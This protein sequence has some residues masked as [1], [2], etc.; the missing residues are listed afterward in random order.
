VDEWIEV[1]VVPVD[2]RNP[3]PLLLDVV[4][5]L[6]HEQLG[7]EVDRWFY[8]WEP[9]LRLRICWRDPARA[10]DH[11]AA[12]TRLLDQAQEEGKL[13]RW[14][15]GNHGKEGEH[16]T[17]EADFYGPEL[18]KLTSNDWMAGSELAL[19]IVKLEAQRSLSKPR[20]FHWDRRVHLFSNQLRQDE[21]ALCLNQ[22]YGY[23]QTY[24]PGDPRFDDVK[25]EI[26]N[27]L[28]P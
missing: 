19:A 1:N 6:V 7:D 24:Y 20:H 17:G 26:E 27:L 4:D 3:E 11:R 25:R 18:W 28:Q 15:E 16:Y 21:I 22:A 9:E 8:F 23:I 13:V 10:A 12:V 2:E 5:P 14:W